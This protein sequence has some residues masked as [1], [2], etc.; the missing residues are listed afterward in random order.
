MNGGTPWL[1]TVAPTSSDHRRRARR[2]ARRAGRRS[3]RSRSALERRSRGS[4]C[5]PITRDAPR[6]RPERSTA[7]PRPGATSRARNVPDRARGRASGTGSSRAR[8]GGSTTNQRS[9]PGRAQPRSAERVLDDERRAVQRAPQHERPRRAV[10]QAAEHH[11]DHQVAVRPRS[12][13]AAVAAERDVEEVAQE[14]RERHVPAPPEVAEARRAV[15]LRRSSAGRRSPSAARGR[16][17]CPCSR[18]SR[19]RSAPRRRRRPA[20]TSGAR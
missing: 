15:G 1:G 14:A 13:P 19:S 12:V 7:S 10:P 2:R 18:R 16:S 17:R 5:R 3:T 4:S 11:R 9:Q 6:A 20:A 8:R